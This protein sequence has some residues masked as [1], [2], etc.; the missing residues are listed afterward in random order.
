MRAQGMALMAATVLLRHPANQI[1]MMLQP[2]EVAILQNLP[3]SATAPDSRKSKIAESGDAPSL[4]R[5][6]DS[7]P[8]ILVIKSPFVLLFDLTSS[9]AKNDG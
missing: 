7:S 4:K 5:Q 3:R 8:A 9:A 2:P 6:L 1:L